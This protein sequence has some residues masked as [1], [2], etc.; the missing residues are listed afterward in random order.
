[1]RAQHSYSPWDI[2][3]AI[4][5]WSIKSVYPRS[6]AGPNPPTSWPAGLS[7][8]FRGLHFAPMSGEWGGFIFLMLIM[9]VPIAYLAGV[10]LYACKAPEP[11]EP[12]AKLAPAPP[13]P[14]PV[15]WAL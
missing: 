12:A 14:P 7:G 13:A 8:H 5:S 3:A 1:M 15:S 6:G 10:G 2:S 4:A 9:K 11:P